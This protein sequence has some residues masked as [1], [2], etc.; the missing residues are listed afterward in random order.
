[1]RELLVLHFSKCIVLINCL[2][3]N[4]AS[5]ALI[6]ILKGL[7]PSLKDLFQFSPGIGINIVWNSSSN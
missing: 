3:I 1:M 6:D 5:I 2:L 4:A 7:S